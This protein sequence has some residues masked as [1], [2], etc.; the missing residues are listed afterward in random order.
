MTPP[1]SKGRSNQYG[2]SELTQ[3]SLYNPP[4]TTTMTSGSKTRNDIGVGFGEHVYE[5]TPRKKCGIVRNK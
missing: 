2:Y 1:V 4:A 3:N 5:E